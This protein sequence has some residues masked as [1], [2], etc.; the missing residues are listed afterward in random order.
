MFAPAKQLFDEIT[1]FLASA[2]DTE[3]ILAFTP[4]DALVQ[5]L[6]ELLERNKTDGLSLDERTELDEF[7]RMNHLL[8]IVRLKAR[9][10]STSDS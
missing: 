8:K 4:S 1:D 2:P 3:A 6:S 9:L 10:R 5:R 7:L